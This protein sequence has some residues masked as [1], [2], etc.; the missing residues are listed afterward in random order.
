MLVIF[1]RDLD[2]VD[3]QEILVEMMAVKFSPCRESL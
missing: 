1:S 3:P 2:I